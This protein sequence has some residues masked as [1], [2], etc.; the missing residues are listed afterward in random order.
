MPF[1]RTS[2][3]TPQR[4]DIARGRYFVSSVR[5]RGEGGAG[6]PFSIPAVRHL[7][8]ARE[9]FITAPVT[10]FIG[11]NGTGKSTLLEAVAV[12][13]GLNPEGG[14]RDH[15]FSTEETHSCLHD[16]IAV[17]RE[18]YPTDTF[19]LR[20]ECFYNTST[21]IARS[22]PGAVNYHV[23]SHGESFLSIVRDR[24]RGNGLYLLDEPEA[25][26]SPQRQMSLLL[27]MDQLVSLN[28]QFIVCTHSPILMAFPGAV[29]LEFSDSGIRP[30]NYRETDHFM[31]TKQF[32][33]RPDHMIRMLFAS[34]S[35]GDGIGNNPVQ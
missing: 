20:A 28:S 10:F 18:A 24:L 23:M 4:R 21:Y 15:C 9:L 3:G 8:E 7:R 29:T 1:H 22:D 5:F 27:M 17:V 16:H 32:M 31:I 19:F 30:V 26:L 13:M 33:T 2:T 25:A 12:A 34:G 6:Y 14:S 11:E 35:G